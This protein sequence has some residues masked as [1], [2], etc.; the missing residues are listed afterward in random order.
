[1]SAYVE[2]ST[3]SQAVV[4]SGFWRRVAASLI[5]SVI[6]GVVG[7]HSWYCFGLSNGVWR[8]R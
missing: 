6:L 3:L 8:D 7:A 2:D 5:D 1:M 4:Y